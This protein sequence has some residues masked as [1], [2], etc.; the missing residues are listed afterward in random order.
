M[1]AAALVMVTVAASAQAWTETEVAR[2][3]ARC[4]QVLLLE[5]SA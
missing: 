3:M 1:K 5:D 4:S 2:A